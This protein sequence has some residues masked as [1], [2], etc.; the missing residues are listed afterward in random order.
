VADL[1]SVAIAA[2]QQVEDRLAALTLFRL[3]LA[4]NSSDV[5]RSFLVKEIAKHIIPELS[6]I[7]WATLV[8]SKQTVVAAR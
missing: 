8:T 5:N 1:P 7:I 4:Y 3:I 6:T 2:A